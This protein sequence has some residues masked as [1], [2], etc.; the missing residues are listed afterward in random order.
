[1]LEYN[2]QWTK[3]SMLLIAGYPGGKIKTEN[4]GK[5]EQ[6]EEKIMITGVNNK[7]RL[8]FYEMAAGIDGQNEGG[9]FYG[10]FVIGVQI[11]KNTARYISR[12]DF[13]QVLE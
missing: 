5:F 2:E 13:H 4:K 12:K 3:E 6:W 10:Y 11:R 7:K 1:M 9:V 8:I